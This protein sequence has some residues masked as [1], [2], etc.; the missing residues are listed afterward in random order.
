MNE[1]TLP[2]QGF[3]VILMIGIV[4]MHT[5]YMPIFGG[6]KDLVPFWFVLS[7]FLYRDRQPWLPYMRKKLLGIYPFYLFIL[8]CSVMI[9]ILR[10]QFVYDVNIF[11]NILMMGCWPI[12]DYVSYVCASWFVASLLWCNALSPFVYKRIKRIEGKDNWLG[13]LLC[14]SVIVIL[15]S[16]PIEDTLLWRWFVYR[17][18]LYCFIEYLT[19][20][21]LWNVIKDSDYRIC[22][23]EWVMGGVIICYI[24]CIYF[25]L[26]QGWSPILHLSIIWIV[27]NYKSKL[28]DYLFANK[29][30][31]WISQYILFIY[32]SHMSLT[33][34]L[35]RG[36]VTE[37]LYWLL[38]INDFFVG[39]LLGVLY[40]MS[41]GNWIKRKHL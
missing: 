23:N 22:P 16:I 27:Y 40:N 15:Q 19:G 34:N 4:C 37:E 36:H 12:P 13:V 39:I 21:F 30:V 9:C 24:V 7:G 33:N 14:M 35:T 32:L 18:P 26:F 6:G 3:R 38:V 10:G 8:F 1:R 25:Q 29:L 28:L 41:V 2:F 31:L 11:T 17:N 20:M 5:Y